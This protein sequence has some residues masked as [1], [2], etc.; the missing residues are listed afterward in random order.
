[1]L[2]NKSMPSVSTSEQVQN[3]QNVEYKDVSVSHKTSYSIIAD[4]VLLSR[5]EDD[6]FLIKVL[7]SQCRLVDL[8]FISFLNFMFRRPELG[9]KFSSRHG[10]KGVCGLISPQVCLFCSLRSKEIFLGRYAI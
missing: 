10:Q 2:I 6:E 3:S 4:K 1:V 8:F 7:Y 5:T 9:D